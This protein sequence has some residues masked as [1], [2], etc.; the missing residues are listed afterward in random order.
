MHYDKN[1]CIVSNVPW[2]ICAKIEQ[3]EDFNLCLGIFLKCEIDFD[4]E[5]LILK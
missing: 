5:K 2:R 1:C 3:T 4:D